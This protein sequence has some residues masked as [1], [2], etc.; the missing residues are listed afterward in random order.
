MKK[1]SFIEGTVIATLAIVITKILGMLYVIPFYAIIGVQGS[2][3]Y[4]YAYNIYVIFLDISSAG[5][6]VAISKI[7]KEYNTLGMMDAKVRAYKVARKII[8][9]ISIA[10]FIVL[11][12]FADNLASLILGD[13]QGGNTISDVAFVIRCVSFAI[14]VIPFLSVSKGYLQGHNIINV[15]SISQVIEQVVRI[16]VI[17]G[18]SYLGLKVLNL[19]LTTSVGIAVFGAFAGGLAAIIY[20]LI[21]MQKNKKELS[22]TDVKKKDDISNKEI[23]KKIISYA[24]PFIIIDVA[25]S[26]YNFI[27]MVLISRTMGYLG[28]DAATTEFVTS[29]V[30]TW[31]NKINV[32]VNSVAMGLTISLIPNIVE[33]FTLKK[34]SL[35]EKRLN[36]AIQI[37]LVT[38]IPMVLGISFLAKPIWNIFYGNSNLDLGSLVLGVS[39]YGALFYNIYMITS[40]TLQSLNKF[41]AVYLTTFLGYIT[42][43]LLDVPLMLLC[44]HL[45]LEPFIGALFATILGYILASTSA[46]IVLRKE[47]AIKYQESYKMFSKILI[48]SLLMMLVVFFVS[49]VCPLSYDSRISCIFYVFVVSFVGA[50]VYLYVSYKM[51]ILDNVFGKEYLEKIIRKITFNKLPRKNTKN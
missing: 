11:F 25:V 46:L 30:A 40:M 38:C 15:S 48:P 8:R 26:L 4:A 6:P 43:A 33:A 27:D 7:I 21:N 18:G 12:L 13:L 23:L 34:W 14:L 1:S 17:L 35:V 20:I 44:Y 2:A 39:I 22:F 37:I 49:F 50:I 32:I 29:S 51:K 41:K 19:S 28:F 9:F 47:H 5:L 31:A 24:I 42:N 45:N 10:A 36:K 16:T 3:L